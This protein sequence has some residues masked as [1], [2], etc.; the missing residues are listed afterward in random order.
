MKFE[1]KYGDY[2]V[3]IMMMMNI[4]ADD[5]DEDDYGDDDYLLT[6]RGMI[7]LAQRLMKGRLTPPYSPRTAKEGLTFLYVI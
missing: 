4:D 7:V 6:R 2:G 1:K 3:K 5:A